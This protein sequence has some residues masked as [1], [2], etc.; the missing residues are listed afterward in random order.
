[1]FVK[2]VVRQFVKANQFILVLKVR[3]QDIIKVF[4][5]EQVFLEIIKVELMEDTTAAPMPQKLG[6]SAL[7]AMT[8]DR[9]KSQPI[10]VFE[11]NDE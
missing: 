4:M 10:R 1:M 8:N 3:V 6:H 2:L 9:S 11:L 5:A 7:G